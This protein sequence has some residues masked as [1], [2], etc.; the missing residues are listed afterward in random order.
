MAKN[1]YY[2]SNEKKMVSE[3]DSEITLKAYL[4]CITKDNINYGH[5]YPI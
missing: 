5:R 4:L 1:Q 3:T 2:N